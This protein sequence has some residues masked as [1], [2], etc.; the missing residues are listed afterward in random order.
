MA[1]MLQGQ[2]RNEV[3]LESFRI[4][5]KVL[6]NILESDVTEAKMRK[7][8]LR[9]PKIDKY[10]VN[11][12]GAMELLLGCGFEL[13]FEASE[14]DTQEEGT[15]VLPLDAEKSSL[16]TIRRVVTAIERLLG[17]QTTVSSRTAH[18]SVA[19]KGENGVADND[20][21][22]PPETRATILELP[23]PIEADVPSWFFEQSS[24]EIKQLYKQNKEKIESGKILMT[25]AMREKLAK[26]NEISCK[27][28]NTT[29]RIR[30]RAPEGTKI[31][32]DFHK[33]EPIQALFSW[34]SD[35]LV[36][37]MLEFDLILP[38]RKKLGDSRFEQKCLLD[39]GLA[40][41][42]TLNLCWQGESIQLMK[43]KPAFREN[44]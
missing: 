39:V 18:S 19:S 29:I 22:M 20:E 4:I 40:A 6:K 42:Q 16:E 3:D 36:D 1:E 5:L 21:V 37:P 14:K 33:K 30:V 38:D 7:L 34:V 35:C 9:N 17:I 11:A 26:R 31:V 27:S 12:S 25:K 13:V 44:I 10:I 15:M 28:S 2:R 23:T 41:S 43:Y 8:R 32:G 24:A